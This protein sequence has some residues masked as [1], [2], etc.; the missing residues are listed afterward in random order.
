MQQ[1]QCLNQPL[2][3]NFATLRVYNVL[4]KCGSEAWTM[5]EQDGRRLIMSEARF[6]WRT[7][8][9]TILD[10]KISEHILEELQVY[11]NTDHRGNHA[12]TARQAPDLQH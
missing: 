9:Y 3:E 5:T 8:G 2:C 12:L 10:K 1:I 4:A 11:S 6:V 7:A